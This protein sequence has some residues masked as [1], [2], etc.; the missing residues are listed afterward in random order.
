[1]APGSLPCRPSG[2]VPL[3]SSAPPCQAL[4]LV[5]YTPAP[6]IRYQLQM[7]TFQPKPGTLLMCDFVGLMAPEMI[8]TRPVVVI[9]P[10]RRSRTRLCTIVPLSTTA[11]NPVEP[12]HHRMNPLSLPVSFRKRDSWAKCDM[13]YTVTLARLDRVKLRKGGRRAY[14]A[15]Q[16]LAEDLDAI[17]QGVVKALSLT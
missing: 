7:L 6:Y 2:G 1:M 9:S 3:C 12:F 15:P 8:K 13:L 5:P 16:V 14:H 17:R 10:R 4:A 11:P